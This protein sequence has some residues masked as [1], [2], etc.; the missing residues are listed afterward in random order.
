M[1]RDRKCKSQRQPPGNIKFNF[2]QKI[3]LQFSVQSIKF[4]FHKVKDDRFNANFQMHV[5]LICPCICICIL[6]AT[7]NTITIIKRYKKCRKKWRGCLKETIKLMFIRPPRLQFFPEEGTKI[8]AKNCY[9]RDIQTIQ[10]VI[11]CER[12]H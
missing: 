10:L 6:F 9:Y 12:W 11:V 3:F 2:S 7:H 4:T 1:L 8:T 5:T